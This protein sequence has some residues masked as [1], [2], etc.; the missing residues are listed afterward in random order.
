MKFTSADLTLWVA[1]YIWPFIRI[2][3]FVGAAPIFGTRNV[4]ARVKIII[5]ASL[6]IMVVPI[7]PKIQYVD[8]LEKT[9]APLFIL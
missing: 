5:A 6:T 2:A 8:P 9:I 7:L 3:A 1:Q 4:P